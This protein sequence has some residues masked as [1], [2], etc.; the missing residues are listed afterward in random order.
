MQLKSY[1]LMMWKA[2]Y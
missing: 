2:I 1:A